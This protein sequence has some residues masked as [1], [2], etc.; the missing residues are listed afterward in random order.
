MLNNILNYNIYA[1]QYEKK[2]LNIVL[3]GKVPTILIFFLQ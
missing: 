2:K 3:L 1:T